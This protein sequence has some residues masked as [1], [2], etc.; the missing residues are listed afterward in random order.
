MT[1]HVLFN[2]AARGGRTRSLA[3]RVERAL[4]E[5]GIEARIRTTAAPGDAER[6]ARELG[7]TGATV[8]VAGG[9]GTVHEAAN[10]LAGTAGTLGVIPVGTGNDYANALGMA[11]APEAAARQLAAAR[12]RSIDVARLAWTDAAGE[13]RRVVANAVGAGFDGHAAGLASQT[14]WLGGRAAYLAAVFRTLRQWPALAPHV[15]SEAEGADLAHDGR[16][17]L[18][19]VGVGHSVGGGFLLTPDAV[20]DDGLL[21]VCLVRQLP[22]TRALQLLPSTFSGGHVAA[23]EVRMGQTPRFSLASDGPLAIQ[24]DGEVLSTDARAFSVT[25]DPGALSVLA[26]RLDARDAASP[27]SPAPSMAR[28]RPAV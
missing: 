28:A 26:P 6:W 20:P 25:I 2:P 13:H 11:T 1:A 24:A 9:D 27:S 5:A 8:L 14:K 10:G 23:P 18:V 16:L 19:E 4:A 17:F 15:R 22:T 7:E 12:P 21:D 3:G